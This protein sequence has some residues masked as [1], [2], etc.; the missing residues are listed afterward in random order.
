MLLQMF[1]RSVTVIPPPGHAVGVVARWIAESC[2]PQSRVLDIGAGKRLSA[3]LKPILRRH[4]YLV[5]IDP[6]PTIHENPGLQERYQMTIEDYAPSHPQDFDVAFAVFVLEHVV[7]PQAFTEACS[8]V[9]RPGGRFYAITLN[10]YQYFGLA[11]W[12][13][14]RLGKADRLL[15]ALKGPER[16]A[17]YHFPTQ[18]RLNSVRTISRHLEAA[19]FSAVEFR[20]FEATARYA[21]YLPPA[22]RWFAGAYSRAAYAIGAPQMMGHLS[23]CAV[24]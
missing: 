5:G 13:A 9:L 19:G 11:T 6:A 3:P 24:R 21:W 14:T 23:F 7:N 1:V 17:E 18:Y 4:P 22:L 12:A 2:S 10:V 8:A 20:C 15:G 16:V